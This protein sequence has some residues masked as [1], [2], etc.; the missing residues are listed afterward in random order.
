MRFSFIE[1]IKRLTEAGV[2]AKPHLVGTP[3]LPPQNCFIQTRRTHDPMMHC[4]GGP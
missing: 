3:H 1:G 2:E 4:A